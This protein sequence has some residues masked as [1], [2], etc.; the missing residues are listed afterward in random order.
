M[1][2]PDAAGLLG[3]DIFR[4]S[5]V[6][7]Y[8]TRPRGAVRSSFDPESASPRWRWA[9]TAVTALALCLAAGL[10]VQVPIGPTGTL[11]RIDETLAVLAMPTADAPP[12]GTDVRLDVAGRSLTGQVREVQSSG[13]STLLVL[14]LVDLR[15]WVPANE[16]TAGDAVTVDEGRWPLLLDLLKGGSQT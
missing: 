11:I 10:L 7:A 5:A 16:F 9:M 8:Y 12:R 14:V 4:P 6:E 2:R 13:G 15:G 1:T 3:A